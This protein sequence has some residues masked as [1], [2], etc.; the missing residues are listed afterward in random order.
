MTQWLRRAKQSV[1]AFQ[2]HCGGND[3]LSNDERALVNRSL[4]LIS[5]LESI[6]GALS[7][8]ATCDALEVS[9]VEL[10]EAVFRETLNVA[11]TRQAYFRA[12]SDLKFLLGVIAK[13]QARAAA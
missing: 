1:A 13:R 4:G 5:A 6:E 3:M 9:P 8:V 12:A 10:I 2:A 11:D 7:F